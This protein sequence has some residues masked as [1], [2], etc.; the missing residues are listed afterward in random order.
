MTDHRIIPVC[1]LEFEQNEPPWKR[2]NA[3][4]FLLVKKPGIKLNYRE[5][6]VLQLSR[7]LD[8]T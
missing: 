1:R 2:V 4:Q 8:I 3:N 7:E 6:L 5:S